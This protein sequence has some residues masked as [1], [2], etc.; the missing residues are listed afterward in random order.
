MKKSASANGSTSG[1]P[2]Y[3]GPN[4]LENGLHR[5][6]VL[7]FETSDKWGG[8]ES[9][10]ANEICPLRQW[11]DVY[12]VVQPGDNGIRERLPLPA[13]RLIEME[14]RYGSVQYRRWLRALLSRQFDI[15]HCNKNSLVKYLPITYAHRYS[16][17][18]III[19]SHNTSPSVN[20]PLASLHYLV[21][22]RIEVL[23]DMRLA[24]SATA[25][26]YMFGL[27]SEESHIINNGIEI[28][29]F[30][31]CQQ[32]RESV[33]KEL[34]I[35]DSDVVLMNVGRFTE[36]KNQTFL[37]DVFERYNALNPSSM[38]VLVGEGELRETIERQINGL[39]L[40]HNVIIT[41]RRNDVQRFFSAADVVVF[42]SLYEGLPVTLVEA[43]AN[44]V[45]I[46]ASSAIT[47]ESDITG[48]IHFEGLDMGA[49]VWAKTL[50]SM[51]TF[52]PD[53]AQRH[54]AA[55]VVRKN[56]Y[57][58]NNGVLQLKSIYESLL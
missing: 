11:F 17:S 56:G 39:G 54:A 35:S 4:V 34:Q 1:I 21:R 25:A 12:V 27:H 10:I 42:P 8:I 58:R 36:Q 26:Q 53:M 40:Q 52:V 7:V 19:H 50:V 2:N 37:I 38:L 20:S 41:G 48:L 18:K 13:N 14:G 49:E 5:P 22:S 47:K 44:G 57:D 33:R 55:E 29:T 3:E 51:E 46:L 24:C 9:F 30:T 23:A 28:D 31:Y 32:D 6:S 15:V 43:Q 45:P 16:R